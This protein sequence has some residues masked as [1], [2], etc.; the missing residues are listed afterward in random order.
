LG[1]DEVAPE[2]AVLGFQHLVDLV[3]GEVLEVAG[4]YVGMDVRNSSHRHMFSGGIR[5]RGAPGGLS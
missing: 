1:F 3:F 2:V 5:Q 4:Y